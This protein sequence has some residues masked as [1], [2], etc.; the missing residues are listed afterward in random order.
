MFERIRPLLPVALVALGATTG[1]AETFLVDFSGAHSA[2]ATRATEHWNV[3]NTGEKGQERSLLTTSG[4]ATNVVL[5]ITGR[6]LEGTG[7]YTD[8]VW[9]QATV[10]W[11]DANVLKGCFWL[12]PSQRAGQVTIAGLDN[13][14]SYKVE[15][16]ASRNKDN[17]RLTADYTVQRRSIK[18]SRS[19]DAYNAGHLKQN[20]M[21]WEHA[22]PE[23]GKIVV[24]VVLTGAYGYLNGMRIS[25]AGP[26]VEEPT[27]ADT[28]LAAMNGAKE[29]VFAIR[30][31]YGDG[32]YYANF[33]HWSSNP[34]KMMHSPDGSRLCK[35]NVRTGQVVTLLDDP[36]GGIRDPRVHYDGK[37]LLFAYRPG[38]T[39]YYHL[40][41]CNTDGSELQQLTSGDWDDFDPEYLPD[42][43]IVFVSSRCNRFVPCYHSQAGILYRMD[44][45]GSNVRLLSANNVDDNRPA[46][47]PD[48]RVVYTR[49]DYVDR[50]PQKFHSLWTMN[51][52]GTNQ[53][54]LFGNTVSP[55]D[56]FFVMIDA[57]PVPDTKEVV[58]AFSPGHGFRENAG[59]VMILDPSTGPDAWD[60]LVQISPERNLGRAGWAGGQ[61]GF[62]DPCPL[63]KD[64]FLATEDT[65]LVLLD[66][67]GTLEEVYRADGII[68]DPRVIR[69]RPRERII[70]TR[71]DP[72]ADTGHLILADVYRGRNMAGVQPGT[73]KKLLILEDLPKPV[74]YYSLEGAL[75]MDG[76]HTLHR[77]L[78]TVP[79]EPDGSASFEV[80][81]LRG[82]FFV[83]LDE[84][85][86]A[87]KRMQSYTMVMP[88]ETQG[89]VGCHEPRTDT[90]S[91]NHGLNTL[92]ALTRPPSSIEPAT[93]IPE[94]IDYPRDIQPIWNSHCV[95]CHNTDT[96][97]GHVVLTD[98]RNE[99]FTQSYYALFAYNQIS[100]SRRYEEDGNHPP[101][102]FGTGASRLMQK[103]D[104]SHYDVVLPKREYDMV[105]LWI[106]SGAVFAGTYAIHNG[107]ESAVAGAL[108]NSSTQVDIGEPLR[109]IVENRCLPCH[110]SIANLGQRVEKVNVSPLY[111]SPAGNPWKGRTNLPKHCW[112]LYNLS[113]PE[114][115]MILLA[116]L[117]E[118][119][120][121][122]GWCKDQAGETTTAFS[123]PEDPD[124]QVILTAIQAAK[125][126]QE[127]MGRFDLPGW[128]L[129]S[130]YVYWMKRFGILPTSFDPAK[131][132]ADPYAADQAYWRSLWYQPAS[133]RH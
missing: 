108:C 101:Y 5:T 129:P 115:S 130:H 100:D 102:D 57:L 69:S 132:A 18:G 38:G 41:E 92:M 124:Y 86:L 9:P 122:Y 10:P 61:R 77:I 28:V 24:D 66:R 94:V 90:L 126:R 58:A 96:P 63:T 107:R 89:C 49:W 44:G 125:A 30:G 11:V 73:I 133:C 91:P 21:V 35:L 84:K 105:R 116:S 81:P 120:G 26:A 113:H 119:A 78:G 104:G 80:P 54:V 22:N 12:S 72:E 110:G 79:V 114:K 52:D 117:P 46:I 48:G 39:K 123:R 23:A 85:G 97:S 70:P 62:R 71:T 40:C 95:T 6:F 7:S 50:A 112:N 65:R 111:T 64:L 25:K 82:L 16:I 37:R 67:Q 42:G 19:F 43:G 15:I 55:S 34:E 74:S 13:E 121:G 59:H 3:L 103:I 56:E 98:D 31:V 45:D 51:P 2:P 75:G 87:V 29:I 93:G 32:H 60:T 118:Q 127:A 1:M 128:Q 131:D 33:G 109:P 36:K 4:E 106:E 76:T 68:H 99:W 53:M 88:G 20:V 47:M 27:P 14:S 83:A 8:N 17:A